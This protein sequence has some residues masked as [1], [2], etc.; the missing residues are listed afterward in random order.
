MN[1]QYL[2][3]NEFREFLRVVI[4]AAGGVSEFCAQTGF[5][6]SALYKVMSGKYPPQPKL[7]KRMTASGQGIEEARVYKL[8]PGWVEWRRHPHSLRKQ[9]A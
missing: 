7:L 9:P 2:T 1:E 3:E 5:D 8:P 4:E 6:R